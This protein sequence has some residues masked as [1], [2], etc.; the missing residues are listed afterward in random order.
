M[1][2]STRTAVSLARKMDA[3]RSGLSGAEQKA[4]DDLLQTFASQVEN[5]DPRDLLNLPETANAIAA[6]QT[7]ASQDAQALAV[8]P[9]ITAT[10]TIVPIS[11]AVCTTVTTIASHRTIGCKAIASIRATPQRAAPPEATQ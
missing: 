7:V 10:R 4:F 2:A 3:F 8:T 5:R 9:V 11:K 1:P 6:M